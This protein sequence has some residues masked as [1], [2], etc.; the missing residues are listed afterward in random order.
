[1][2]VNENQEEIIGEVRANHIGSMSAR[3]G[4]K[5][6]LGVGAGVGPE[7]EV[8]VDADGLDVA[9]DLGDLERELPRALLA[10]S[11]CAD[12]RGRAGRCRQSCGPSRRRRVLRR[13]DLARAARR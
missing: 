4:K 11:F 13:G 5:I 12:R 6:S 1:M 2:N 8:E 9:R 3:S 10:V 7:L